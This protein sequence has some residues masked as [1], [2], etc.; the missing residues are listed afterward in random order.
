MSMERMHL[1]KPYK[2]TQFLLYLYYAT[3]CYK[4]Q[5]ILKKQFKN[6]GLER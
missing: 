1:P 6:I 4:N 2:R 5:R 3:F